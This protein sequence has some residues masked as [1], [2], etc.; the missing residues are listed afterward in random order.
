MP[1]LLEGCYVFW[2]S[3]IIDVIKRKL[4]SIHHFIKLERKE[5]GLQGVWV[6]GKGRQS[7]RK[8]WKPFAIMR[9]IKPWNEWVCAEAIECNVA[10]RVT[11]AASE[12]KCH[13][14]K[15]IHISY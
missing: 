11:P 3:G 14:V 1:V 2:G 12:E 5:N 13:F 6:M 7:A 9:L 10:E 15:E 8:L 4:E